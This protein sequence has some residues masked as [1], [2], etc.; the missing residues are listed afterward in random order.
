MLC[1]PHT[2]TY[3]SPLQC[4]QNQRISHGKGLQLCRRLPANRRLGKPHRR[5]RC[6][7][8]RPVRMVQ[9]GYHAFCMPSHSSHY[10]PRWVPQRLARVHRRPCRGESQEALPAVPGG[11]H[12]DHRCRRQCR[13]RAAGNLAKPVAVQLK[14]PLDDA[15]E[16]A[17]LPSSSSEGC[18]EKEAK[19]P[20]VADLRSARELRSPSC[21]FYSKPSTWVDR[22]NRLTV[23]ACCGCTECARRIYSATKYRR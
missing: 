23:A 12:A 14:L 21:L 1:V 13:H 5:A 6:A 8:V 17:I 3:H 9:Q 16:H 4:S 7:L 11:A 2:H 20:P 19:R 22:R 15:P 18:V 10:G